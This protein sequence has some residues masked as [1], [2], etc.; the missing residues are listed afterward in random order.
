MATGTTR[1]IPVPESISV[2]YCFARPNGAEGVN[3]EEVE[4]TSDTDVEF[5]I[6]IDNINVDGQCGRSQDRE[7]SGK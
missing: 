5:T 2:G 7:Q 6:A 1:S 4:L 3:L